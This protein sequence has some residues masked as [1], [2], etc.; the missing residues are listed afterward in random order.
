MDTWPAMSREN[1]D[2]VRRSAEPRFDRHDYPPCWS[3]EGLPE[4]GKLALDSRPPGARGRRLWQR[5]LGTRRA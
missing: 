1:V 4:G 3:E 5:N 2:V